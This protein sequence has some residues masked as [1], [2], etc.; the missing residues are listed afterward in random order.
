MRDLPP[1]LDNSI[2]AMSRSLTLLAFLGTSS[3]LAAAP[4]KIVFLAGNPSHGPGEHEHRAG[5]ML[6]ADHLNKSGLDVNAVVTTNG[7]PK[8]PAV[9]D[10]MTALVMYSDGGGGHPANAH[11]KELKEWSAKGVGIGCLH[12]AV[13]VPKGEPGDTFLG[14]VGGYFE[15]GWSVNPHW[16]AT[17]KLPKHEIT[18]GIHDFKSSDE[19]Y[20][21]MRFPED[22]TGLTSILTDLPPPSSLTRPDGP[23]EGN[24]EVRNAVLERK[25]P[26][27]VMWVFEKDKARGF[28]FTGGHFHKNWQNDDQRRVVL[29]AILWIARVEVPAG[30]IKSA[31]PTDEEMKANLD[32]K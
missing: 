25:E 31:T 27:S 10:G 24:P 20:Y 7:W 4:Q 22:K 11:L 5:C 28:G 18:Q 13:E 8:D 6:L 21:H 16:E 23:H 2:S 9:F 12:Y 32:Q 3:F 1:S 19:W 14:A 15:A 30:G 29:N 26:Q 17:F